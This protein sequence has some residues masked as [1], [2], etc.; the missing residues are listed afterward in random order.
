MP[1]NAIFSWFIGKLQPRINNYRDFPIE[2]QAETFQ[3]LLENGSKTR[4]GKEFNIQADLTL[5]DFQKKVPLQDYGTLKPLIDKSIEGEENLLWPGK[6]SWFAKSSGTTADRIKI[7]PITK[8][9]LF[10]NHY[11]GGK[12]LLAQYYTNLPNRKL[13][14]AKHLII[15]GSGELKTNEDGV[16]IGDLSAIIINNLPWWTELRRSPKKE[17]A[18]LGN[19][20]EKLNRMAKAVIDENICIIAGVPSWTSLL[21]KK[22]LQIS[23][24]KTILE[25]WPNLELYIHGGM[26]FAPYQFTFEKLIGG[27]INYVESYNSSEGYFG[28][29]DQLNSKD[30]LLLTQSQ[31]FYEFIPMSD[32]NGL[33]SKNVV[34]LKDVQIQEEYALV[35]TTSSGLWRYIIGDTVRFTSTSPYRFV[36][37]GRISHFINAFGEKLIVE[38]AEK[39]IANA[40]AA[41]QS[42]II[43]FTVAPAFFEN[44]KTGCHEWIIEFEEAPEDLEN[45]KVLLDSE[46]KKQNADYDAKR[47]ESLNIDF[48]IVHFVP[49]GTFQEWLKSKGK[50]GGQHKV[51]RLMND[52]TILE[53][54]LQRIS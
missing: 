24:K 3:F 28:L 19:W 46:L 1:F 16:F 48:P 9:S 5:E 45:F 8:D 30:L 23:E 7:L 51:P 32:F 20:E 39:A 10:E 15:G 44:T 25:V 53:Q 50:L 2:C 35:I 22:V 31:A 49:K 13:Y 26:N 33:Q 14:N 21:L 43:D 54:I 52:R 40:C 12:D 27:P 42:S 17:I 18:L 47:F 36:V 11:A 6:T 38:H 34:G 37:S 29:Q 41:N 4:F